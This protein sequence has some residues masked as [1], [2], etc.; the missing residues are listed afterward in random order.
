MILI[1]LLSKYY[2]DIKLFYFLKFFFLYLHKNYKEKI[3]LK[4]C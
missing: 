3:I 2:H 4:I 1:V